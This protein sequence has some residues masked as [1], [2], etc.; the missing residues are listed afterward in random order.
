MQNTLAVI[1]L[2][3]IIQNALYVKERADA[4]LIAVVK[5][6]AYGHGAERVSLALE[7]YVRSFAVS[8]AAEG[9]ALRIAGVGKEILILSPCLSEEEVLSC[10]VY[11]LT[12]TITSVASMRLMV[13][14]ANKY[15]IP[16]KAQIKINTGMNR[17]GL[18]PDRVKQV[19]REFSA[20]DGMVTGAY[21]H[22]YAPEDG[23]ARESQYELFSAA[24]D[25]VLSFF[26]DAERH[27]SATGGILAGNKYNFDAVRCGIALYGY[28]PHGF[29]GEL[30][31]RPAMR[32]YA[33]A[34]QSG[35]FTGGG[36]C[37][38]KADRAYGKLC[39]LRLGYGDGFPRT[40]KIENV[41]ALCM[42]ACVREEH[43]A[44]GRLRLILADAEAYARAHDTV[45]Y[46][47]LVNV[48]KKA[49]KRYV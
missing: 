48:T 34:A 5:D 4:P 13:K 2:N 44:F 40:G 31:V 26:P 37:Y 49:E 17:Y 33:T 43:A 38:K 35:K 36:V 23:Q 28:L 32:V 19:C 1:N 3:R 14:A 7:P 27:L 39:T 6:D 30:P 25:M 12:P 29:E 21:S 41:H 47:V 24:A 10:A 18:R 20:V 15:G 42:D 22:F 45:V 11:D 8:T 46:E 9:A 16:L